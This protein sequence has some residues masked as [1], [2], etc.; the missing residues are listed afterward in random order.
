ME[1]QRICS[2]LHGPWMGVQPLLQLRTCVQQATVFSTNCL[3]E[4]ANYLDVSK[5]ELLGNGHLLRL[6]LEM[7]NYLNEFFHGVKKK[8][9]KQTIRLCGRIARMLRKKTH[10]MLLRQS[11]NYDCWPMKRASERIDKQPVA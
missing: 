3:L 11:R 2:L 4:M 9:C 1:H 7:A 8:S 10:W 6:F 5:E